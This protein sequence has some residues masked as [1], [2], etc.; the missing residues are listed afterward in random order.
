MF[1]L[2]ASILFPTHI[3]HTMLFQ[4]AY[5]V[6]HVYS[7]YGILHMVCHATGILDAFKSIHLL[8]HYKEVKKG[9]IKESPWQSAQALI[10]T[11]IW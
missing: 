11:T 6:L 10:G 3:V 5:Y 8:Y 1:H 4:S 7:L 2:L 9:R